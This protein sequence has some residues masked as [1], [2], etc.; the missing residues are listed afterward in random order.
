M[1][2]LPGGAVTFLFSDIEG[3]TR[4]VKALRER[5]P[6]IL[7]EHR[8]L[9]RAAIAGQAGHEVDIQGDAFFAAF[10]GAKQAALC[11]LEIQR[12]LTAHQWPAGA[13]VRVRIGIHTGHAVPADGAYT[14]LAVHRAARICATARG[15]QVLVSQA[16]QTII[17]DEEEDPGFTLL[18]V[19][20]R[21]LKDLDR[22]VR[23]FQLA[24]PGLDPQNP[25]DP[26]PH[27]QNPQDP[28]IPPGVA[29]SSPLVGRAAEIDALAA[30]YAAAAAGQ[31]RVMLLTG[32]AGIG[33]TRLVEELCGRVRSAAGG[34]QVRVG[35]SA[36][37]TGATLAF[38]P[39]VAALGDQGEWLLAGDGGGDMLA[40]RH[41]LFVQVLQLL[42]G[43]AARSPLVLV[44][45]DLHWADESSRELL[46]FLAVR[47]RTEPVLVVG[48]LREEE[49]AAGTRRWLA[50]LER[51]SEVTRIRLRPLAD[52]EVAGLVAGL[53]PAGS[54][55]EQ[56]AAVVGAAEGNPLYARELAAAG[57]GG[58]PGSISDGVL[59]R[60]AGLP[61]APRAVVQQ[62]C[63][64]DGGLS[65]DLL[66]STVSLT[67][68]RLLAAARRAVASGLLI[69]GG[70]G[71]AFR[72]ELIRQVVYTHLLPGERQRLHRRL[73][74]TLSAQPGSNPGRLAQ[75]W[76]LAGCPDRAGPAAVSAARAA[77]Q[78]RAYPE[79]LRCYALAVDL[80]V[81]VPERGPG[82]LEEAAQAASWAGD[83]QRAAEWAA[84]ALTES[85]TAQS[86]PT[87]PVDRARR[88]ER[89]ARYQWEAGDLRAAVDGTEQAI[90][91]LGDDPPSTLQAR[92]LAA[93]ATLRMLLG[94]FDAALPLA[95]RA[96]AVAEQADAVAA[97]A[98][99]LATLGIIQA[100]R[101]ELDAGL[102]ALGTSFDL[103]RQAGSVEDVARAAINHMYL[104]CTAGRFTEA[105]AVARDGRKATALL[106][107]PT[108]LTSVLDNNTAAVLIYTGRWQQAD[109][110]LAELVGQSSGYAQTYLQLR[111]LEL[112][113]GRGE[114]RAAD[115]AAAVAKVAE[116]NPRILGP[117]HGCLAE[118]ALYAGDLVAAAE[119]VLDGLAALAGS[120]L[121]AD[122]IRLLAAGARVAADLASL[123]RPARP[124]G[125]GDQWAAAAAT[126]ADRARAITEPH[127][128][129][130]H[131][132]AAFG[133]L[134]AA[135]QARERGTD[136]RA[137]WRA[138][139]EAWRQAGQPY[140]EA[141]AR[142]REAE[143][144]VRAGRRDQ[145]AR[146]LATCEALARPLRSSPLLAL[147]QDV[148][149]R[150]RLD[151]T[152]P[153]PRTNSAPIKE[154]TN[155]Q[156]P[157]HEGRVSRQRPEDPR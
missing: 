31:S 69:A 84:L 129:G 143:A 54:G 135:E 21:K 78:A 50:E 94:E 68:E 24:A 86:G 104:L 127:S 51:R 12:A 76:Q 120:T 36:P 91:L 48:T 27:P 150:A 23:L 10:A 92:V 57:P 124:T 116:D 144:A 45:E 1:S 64:A 154:D 5:Y 142:L 95:R 67:E 110:L 2:D 77:V 14:G 149:L 122:E 99:G 103:A 33:K 62:V 35:E 126:F 125:L 43:L 41:R 157:D 96:V 66:A 108:A 6:Q 72:H 18:D 112:A 38:G 93:H 3:S 101:G 73:A 53:L 114:P 90:D 39:F 49:L 63:V 70:D 11:A 97:H 16:T 47:L 152:V 80:E 133:V 75:H 89:L 44:L 115:L 128:G 151:Q 106:G 87:G 59:A 40:A 146:A 52:A 102:A 28:R 20:E 9:V 82:L 26:K 8:R 153:R 156:I 61:A 141:Y 111:Q 132:V 13:P 29:S 34:A 117:L 19:G 55:A 15:G 98:Q 56:V 130:Q 79:A 140:R 71:Y 32:E 131:E 83:P 100:Q 74:E 109:R 113:V 81:W 88:L 148:A 46:G 17:E 139:A 155:A 136:S 22:P 65:H 42:A 7:A 4:L 123:P 58:L 60:A 138:A 85:G 119:E 134:V 137:T 37:L 25:K 147:A 145:A 105:L 30:A 121:P 107:T 118:E